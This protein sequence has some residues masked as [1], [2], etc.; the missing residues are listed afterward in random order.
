M[1]AVFFDFD[2]VLTTDKTG[3]LSICKYVSDKSKIDID[4][5]ADAY[6]QYNDKLLYGQLTHRDVWG[7]ICKSLNVAIPY[8]ILFESFIF[9]PVD[10]EVV[11]L[12]KQIKASGL[13][14]GM[15]T[16]NKRDRID[17]IV[18][19]HNWYSLFDVIAVSSTVGSGKERADIFNVACNQAEVQPNESIF[20]DNTETNLVIPKA[21]GMKT[22][23]YDDMSRK[24]DCLISY[25][26][27]FGISCF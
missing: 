24:T 22:F 26:Q 12:V 27:T 14:T 23:L 4:I 5:F 7:D 6:G 8:D 25:L 20:I 1:K 15:I 16:D 21:M 11:K 2:G 18:A 10:N 3:S 13:K 17:A 19:Y 9:T